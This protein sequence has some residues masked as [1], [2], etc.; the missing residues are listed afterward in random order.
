M[1]KHTGM[2][3]I[4]I[5]ARL[6][7]QTGVGTYLKNLL[8]YLDEL[9]T[10]GCLFFVYLNKNDFKLLNFRSKNFI[11][12]DAPYRWHTLSEQTDFL[13]KINADSLDLMHFT[14]FSYPVLYNRPFI[15]TIHDVIPYLHKTGRASSKSALNYQIKHITYKALI[16][17]ALSKAKLIITPSFTVKNQLVKLFS[18]KI[19]DKIVPLYEGVDYQIGA[20]VPDVRLKKQYSKPFFIYIGNFYP[21]KNVENLI[22]A[23]G[24]VKNLANLVLIG[25]DDFFAK[26]IEDLISHEKLNERVILHKDASRE[27]LV[28]FYKNALA[29]IHPS[30][31]EGFGLTLV[32]AA[33][34]KLPIIA[35]DLAVF[36]EIF[37][38]KYLKFKPE[39]VADISQKIS[40]FLEKRPKFDYQKVLKKTSFRK[41]AADTLKIYKQ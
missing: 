27:E 21:H 35:S 17:N 25:P 40:Y 18:S 5:D 2:R 14:Y 34:F 4:G 3:K 39:K 23:F 9:N 10:Q 33:H 1:Q 8:H 41:M 22:K 32:E 24:K 12:K 36:N 20:V 29:L 11:K 28:F 19:K 13:G 31:A 16:S 26:R 7:G 38:G 30:L 37:E 6:I 15:I